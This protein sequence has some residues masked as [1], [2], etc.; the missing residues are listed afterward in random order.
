MSDEVRV[1][2]W[3][4]VPSD[5]VARVA[6]NYREISE[7]LVGVPGLI[8]NELLQ[9]VDRPEVVA[10]TSRW[11]SRRDLDEWVRSSSHRKT[12][13]LRPYLDVERQPPYETFDVL[14]AY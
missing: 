10:V 1:I 12:T 7:Q 3:Y 4:R 6:E 14:S 11:T 2:L 9:A 8:S 13:P 5:D